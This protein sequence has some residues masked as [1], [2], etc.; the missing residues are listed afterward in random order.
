LSYDINPERVFYIKNTIIFKTHLAVGTTTGFRLYDIK[1][2]KLIAIKEG[3][4]F[5]FDV[6]YTITGVF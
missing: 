2:S 4:E 5:E 6:I 1:T 3:K